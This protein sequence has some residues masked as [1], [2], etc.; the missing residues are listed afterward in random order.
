MKHLEFC[1]DCLLQYRCQRLTSRVVM[2]GELT[3]T[4][5]G[6]VRRFMA[7]LDITRDGWVPYLVAAY[8]DYPGRILHPN[9]E[10]LRL[11]T[12]LLTGK[13]VRYW[14]R[15]LCEPIPEGVNP[16]IRIE[17]R[18]RFIVLAS[19]L[20]AVHP[21]SALTWRRGKPSDDDGGVR[22]FPASADDACP[23]RLFVIGSWG[24]RPDRH[25]RDLAGLFGGIPPFLGKNS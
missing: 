9:G 19:I 20:R 11:N 23:Y 2:P 10:E 18:G 6:N 12:H 25:A 21:I 1:D 7:A 4:F 15:D 5:I 14:F 16:R 13:S 8:R 24:G 17:A 3:S 22:P